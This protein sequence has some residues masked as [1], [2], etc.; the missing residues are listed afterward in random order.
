MDKPLL[1]RVILVS[2]AVR[3]LV[4]LHG[5]SGERTPPMY[6]DFEAQRHWMEVT[7]HLPIGD[8]YRSTST[9]DLQYWGLDYPPLTAY[10]SWLCGVLAQFFDPVSI[11][12][13]ASHGYEREEHKV[14]MRL[15][16]LALDLLVYFPA[17]RQLCVSRL[18]PGGAR[19][20]V[21]RLGLALVQP[22]I[23]LV[24]HGHFQS[25]AVS[26]GLALGGAS[27]CLYGWEVTGSILY[28]LS[29]NFK[30]MSLYYAPAFFF[31]LLGRRASRP[32]LLPHLLKLALAV[33]VTFAA[34]WAPFC[35]QASPVGERVACL[36]SLRVVL[37]RLFPFDRGLFEDKVAN[38]WYVL[39][40]LVDLRSSASIGVQGLKALSLCATV[41][42]VSPSAV[43]L[44]ARPGGLRKKMSRR[45]HKCSATAGFLLALFNCGLAFFLCSFQVHEKSF[46]L[47]LAPL[48]FLIFEDPWFVG[49]MS[50]VATFSMYPLLA[51]DNLQSTYV[52]CV[53]IYLSALRC[54]VPASERGEEQLG[55]RTRHGAT[56][57]P[58]AA[59]SGK[60][61]LALHTLSLWIPPPKKYPDLYALIFSVFSFSHFACGWLCGVFWQLCSHGGWGE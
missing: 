50:T 49:W 54:Y 24:D 18:L 8:W 42:L 44:V 22:A 46:L 51:R 37:L 55:L 31:Y 6:G 39:S 25:N 14:F 23:I 40:I 35:I 26:V 58:L 19:K 7:L 32:R 56:P 36:E 57:G 16:V 21:L 61:M 33:F 45:D 52:A 17:A 38:V 3:Y 20:G 15:T 11:E 30:Q 1:I 27:A 9:N 60:A 34:L 13:H 2:I 48:A 41:I 10:A 29:L 28:C 59:L 4:S 53:V 12:L 5:H 43:D 47:P